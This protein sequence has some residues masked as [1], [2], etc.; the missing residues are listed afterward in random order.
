LEFALAFEF[1]SEP[2]PKATVDEDDNKDDKDDEDD[3][4]DGDDTDESANAGFIETDVT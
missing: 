1:A 3:D 2:V 4:E